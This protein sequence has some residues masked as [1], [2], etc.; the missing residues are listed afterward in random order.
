[1]RHIESQVTKLRSSQKDHDKL[2]K[3]REFSERKIRDLQAEIEKVGSPLVIL[4]KKVKDDTDKF[5]ETEQRRIKE[6]GGLRKQIEEYARKM[7]QS[8]TST[9]KTRQK[10]DR[11]SEELGV[12]MKKLKDFQASVLPAGKVTRPHTHVDVSHEPL[13]SETHEMEALAKKLKDMEQQNTRA[14]NLEKDIDYYKSMNKELKGKLREFVGANS[15]LVSVIKD[16]RGV[17]TV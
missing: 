3:E 17:T 9:E 5:N 10:L 2:I 14:V 7:R 8:E 15:K 6:V 16:L 1:M 4:K 12:A 11:K 13:T